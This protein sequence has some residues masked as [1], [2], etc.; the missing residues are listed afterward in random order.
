MTAIIVIAK[1]PV[2]GRS[3]T[4]LCPPCDP[5]EAATIAEAALA[6]TLHAV[7]GASVAR[8]VL[9]L[10]GAAGD[11]LPGGF[12]VVAQGAGGLARRLADA[13]CA[14]GEPAL[15]IGMDT[16]Q[17][18]PRLLDRSAGLLA[19]GDAVLGRACD[20]GYWAIG[21][22]RPDPRVFANVPMSSP[23]TARRQMRR[24]TDL[25]LRPVELPVLRDVDRFDDARAVAASVP[26]SRFA[27]AVH[28]SDAGRAPA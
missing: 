3:K 26:G 27:R 18:T 2:A 15:L 4:R 1:A 6:D 10:D 24:L 20:G 12:E 13:F 16:P 9:V 8:R 11:W 28:A 25:G 22:R 7:A 5:A 14:V 17:V 21:L 19:R 23:V